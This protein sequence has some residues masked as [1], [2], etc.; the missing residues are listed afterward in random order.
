MI[1]RS[2]SEKNRHAGSTRSSP[3]KLT[4]PS[5]GSPQQTNNK[6][7]PHHHQQQSPAPTKLPSLYNQECNKYGYVQSTPNVAAMLRPCESITSGSSS[8]HH[9][10]VMKGGAGHHHLQNKKY[11]DPN[12]IQMYSASSESELLDGAAIL[13][14]FQKLL[15]ERKKSS[16]QI[17]LSYGQ[18]CP[19]ISIKC[20]IVE[21]L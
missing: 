21:Y 7:Q 17:N 13:P 8:A 18:S 16:Q 12:N 5:G 1:H 11:A 19:N 20:D 15:T 3:S 9:H 10:Q 6:S 14:I 4:T 2:V